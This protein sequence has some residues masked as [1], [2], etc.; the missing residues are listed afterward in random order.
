MLPNLPERPELEST[1]YRRPVLDQSVLVLNRSWLPV[2][3][4]TVKRAICMV[5]QDIAQ[6]IATD[7]LQTHRF[8]DWLCIEF[9]SGTPVITTTS[10]PIPAPEVI[11]LHLYNK[12]PNHEAPFTRQN[13]YHRDKF[14]CQ[15][16]ARRE[17]AAHMSIDHVLPRSKGG[18]TNWENCVLAC[19]KCN[20]R[21]A[22]RSLK[23]SGLRL[24]RKPKRP[25]WT[26][27]MNLAAEDR[28]SSWRRFT[29]QSD[30][31]ASRTG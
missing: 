7:T 29:P 12:V 30:W 3:V 9:P 14:T 15:Y 4:T 10:F 17:S 25:R 5:F 24:R 19:V 2:H 21:K 20:A 26:P 27:Y 18:Q 28:L 22:D 16:C 13:L 1:A 31:D 23:E 8:E 11:Q 6:V